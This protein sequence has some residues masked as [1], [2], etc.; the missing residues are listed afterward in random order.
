MG[1]IVGKEVHRQVEVEGLMWRKG[2]VGEVVGEVCM[3]EGA[4]GR[5]WAGE[6]GHMMGGEDWR[7]WEGQR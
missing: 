5:R 1:H 7:W 6:E 3:L 2:L 4:E